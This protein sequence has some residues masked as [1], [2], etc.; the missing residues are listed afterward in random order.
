VE[1]DDHKVIAGY[2]KLSVKHY[3]EKNILNTMKQEKAKAIEKW[4]KRADYQCM[5]AVRENTAINLS[6]DSS[7]DQDM[8]EHD[9]ADTVLSLNK[10]LDLIRVKNS[11]F[12]RSYD[13]AI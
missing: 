5:I 9:I 7:A 6:S 3:Y 4:K 1:D 8:D 13:L 2:L 10:K 12:F 11:K